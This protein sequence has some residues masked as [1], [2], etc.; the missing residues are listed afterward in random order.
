MSGDNWRTDLSR[1]E[2]PSQFVKGLTST[3]WRQ[4]PQM[5]MAQNPRTTHGVNYDTC[6]NTIKYM[7]DKTK[8]EFIPGTIACVWSCTEDHNKM[9]PTDIDRRKEQ[10][11]TPDIP[12][13]KKMNLLFKTRK[14]IVIARYV[15]HYIGL[16]VYT[17]K[18]YG[19]ESKP[20]M[21]D[22]YVSIRNKSDDDSVGETKHGC[23]YT[24]TTAQDAGRKSIAP[25]ANVWFTF[26]QALSYRNRVDFLGN[27][28]P[29]SLS[30]LSELYLMGTKSALSTTL[31]GIDPTLWSNAPYSLG[32]EKRQRPAD[33]TE[34]EGQRSLANTTQPVNQTY[35]GA[36]QNQTYTGAIMRQ[37]TSGAATGQTASSTTGFQPVNQTYLGAAQNQTY[38]GATMRQTTPGAATGQTTS[39]TTG[40]QP[41]KRVREPE[42]SD[43]APSNLAKRVQM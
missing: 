15:D 3:N 14:V 21:R 10:L 26:P 1:N 42:P 12:G 30:Y 17:H 34:P 2:T 4:S 35:L 9:K 39:S 33:T 13:M 25:R 36:A 37:T 7:G 41:L 6:V 11:L 5:G 23:I 22:E 24:D 31:T 18:G 43:E 28:D 19:L 16:P 40:F 8:H 20:E 38:A 27:L 32:S 29:G